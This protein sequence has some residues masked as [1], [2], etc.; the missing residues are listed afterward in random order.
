M[1]DEPPE[2]VYTVTDFYDGVR[3]G[4]AY[5]HGAPHIYQSQF[6]DIEGG[7]ERACEK[8]IFSRV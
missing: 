7:S 2:A 5:F 6:E 8:R 3:G 4:V 1:N